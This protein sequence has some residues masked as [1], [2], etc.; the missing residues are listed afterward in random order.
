MNKYK[1]VSSNDA[2][3]QTELEA[4]TFQEAVEEALETVQWYI[5]DEGDYYTGVNDS[6]PND[7]VELS[8]QIYEDAQYEILEKLG[9][10]ISSPV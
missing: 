8:E 9:Y 10:F 4:T 1:L 2:N 3:D 6:D 7:V 5:I